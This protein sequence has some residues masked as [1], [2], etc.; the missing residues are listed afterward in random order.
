MK[1]IEAFAIMNALPI[2]RPE[3]IT[4]GR[5]TLICAP[6]ADDESLGCGGLIAQLCAATTP[7]FVLIMTDGTGSHPHSKA[8]PSDRLRAL[9]EAETLRAC[10]CL[11]L[12]ADRVAFMGLTDTEAPME[13]EA[14]EAAVRWLEAFC[15]RH[16]VGTVLSTWEHDPHGDHVA[17]HRIA[18]AAA[19]GLHHWAYPVWG[20]T[21]ADQAE[22]RLPAD[23][24]RLDIAGQLSQKR[25][26]IASHRS[27]YG[28]LIDDD[29]TGFRLP[30]ALLEV[31]DR[32]FE[33]FLRLHGP[34]P[35]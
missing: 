2:R 30:P 35:L 29:P 23:G 20:W 15:Q 28:G 25:R 19:A 31:F 34:E 6:H 33:T 7:P 21:L 13:G 10:A 24:I 32:P 11:G 4:A 12:Q 27:Q 26:A 9:R 3:T 14:F 17:V 18:S 22:V 8:Y 5:V 16:G 1:A